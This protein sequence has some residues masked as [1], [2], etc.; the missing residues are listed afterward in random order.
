MRNKTNNDEEKFTKRDGNK[1]KGK[2]RKVS[3]TSKNRESLDRKV[4]ALERDPSVKF[5]KVE[6]YIKSKEL[7]DQVSQLSF[8]HF[9]GATP[10]D[11]Y[12]VPTIM[13]IFMNPAPGLTYQGATPSILHPDKS[14]L[15]LAA[16]KLYVKLSMHSGRNM[17][18]QPQDVATMILA[19]SQIFA[20][21]SYVRRLFG[22]VNISNVYNR[23]FPKAAVEAMGI[24]YDD[25]VA[26]YS[27]YRTRYNAL[28]ATVNKVPILFNCG[29]LEKSA[30]QYDFMF[31]DDE[32]PLSQIYMYL[33]ASTWILDEQSYQGGTILHTVDV[34]P[35]TGTRTFGNLFTGVIRPM[36]DALLTSSTLN[37]VY[38]D[39]LHLAQSDP[40][41]KFTTIDPIV[42]GF[43]VMPIHSY[44]ALL[45]IHNMRQLIRPTYTKFGYHSTPLNDVYPD[46]ENNTLWYNPAF[47][48][49]QVT[50]GTINELVLL[51]APQPNPD[52]GT[53]LEM[54]RYVSTW[55]DNTFTDDGVEYYQY[56]V[57][58][59]YYVVQYDVIQNNASTPVAWGDYWIDSNP[60][61]FQ[62]LAVGSQFDWAPMIKD[63]DQTTGAIKQ[64][65]GDLNYFTTVPVQYMERMNEVTYLGLF[66][67]DNG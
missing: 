21:H 27:D 4:G 67:M 51:D 16:I 65:H 28:V 9:M 19:L 40:T 57:M 2:P 1:G 46:T 23:M 62:R 14:G 66:D 36:V 56:A 32:S 48:K 54:M 58:S 61:S 50:T 6:Y 53:R 18:Y 33:P 11:D 63:I 12:E 52:P 38:A 60:I 47:V 10:I 5:N 15:N 20:M 64:I 49:S 25:F 42:D 3:R 29:Y 30:T 7:L 37:L 26:S 39:L 31:T 41:I 17:T 22:T 8:Q 24:D 35:S 44:E 43:A 45:H 34:V 55:T 59:D 13:R